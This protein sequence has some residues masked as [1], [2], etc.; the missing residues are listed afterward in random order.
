MVSYN[1]ALGFLLIRN[2]GSGNAGRTHTLAA[3]WNPPQ[4]FIPK[5][6][7]VGNPAQKVYIADGGRYSN[8]GVRPDAEIAAMGS[9]GGAFAD[10][11]APQRFS[12]SWDRSNAPGN[13]PHPQNPASFDARVYAYRHGTR[14]QKASADAFRIN[15]GFFDGHV[16]TLGDLAASNPTF[17][18]PKGTELVATPG[19]LQNDVLRKYFNNQ[20]DPKFI[21]P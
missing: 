16:E 13:A 1:T 18:F 20:Q 21:V 4:S 7:K 6:N 19:Q 9:F 14:Q 5:I 15:V 17:W 8:A 12:N 2:T 11:G 3:A 10:Q